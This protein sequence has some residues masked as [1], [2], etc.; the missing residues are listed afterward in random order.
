MIAHVTA[1]LTDLVLL[2]QSTEEIP[3]DRRAYVDTS[4]LPID[5]AAQEIELIA[6]TTRPLRWEIGGG[7]EVQHRIAVAVD[8]Q[9]T[10]LAESTRRRDLIAFDLVARYLDAFQSGELAA[11]DPDTGQ[12]VTRASF[13]IDYRPLPTSIEDTN[14]SATIMFVIDAQLDR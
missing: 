4:A 7:L 13:E 8:V 10:E 1:L 5:V 6:S 11:S 3:A 9:H 14:A 12:Y 2:P